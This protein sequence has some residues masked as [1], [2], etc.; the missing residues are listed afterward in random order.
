VFGSAKKSAKSPRFF[1]ETCGAEVPRDAKK[2][3][4]CG[5]YFASIRCP[6]CG[7]VGDEAAFKGGCP[8]CAYSSEKTDRTLPEKK[9]PSGPLSLWVYILTAAAFAAVLAALFFRGIN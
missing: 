8:T 4:K 5:K 9:N 3:I 7:F 6:A 1:C 2:C